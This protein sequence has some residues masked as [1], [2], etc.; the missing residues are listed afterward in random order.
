MT[1]TAPA[2]KAPFRRRRKDARPSELTTAALELFVERGYA[3]TRL[4][5]VAARAGVS[6]GTLYLYFRSKEALFKAVIEEGMLTVLA[7]A[8]Q[9]L[10]DYRG[11]ATDLLREMLLDWWQQIGSTPMAGVS[12]LILCESSNFP[13]LAEYYQEQVITRGRA[14]LRGVLRRGIEGG[15]FRA[16][17]I[18]AAIGVIIAPL[19]MLAISRFSLRLCSQEVTAAD[20]LTTHV[21]LL[22]DGLRHHPDPAGA[23]GTKAADERLR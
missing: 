16:L 14:L 18:E 22:L 20:Y 17:D 8:E 3:A 5:D 1:E 12:K 23:T 6:K 21:D 4:D 13:Q 19:L 9:R 10:A 2:E 7:A 15:E 11:P